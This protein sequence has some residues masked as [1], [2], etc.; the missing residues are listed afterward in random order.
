MTPATHR[1]E[2]SKRLKERSTCQSNRWCFLPKGKLLDLRGAVDVDASANQQDADNVLKT[3]HLEALDEQFEFET[4]ADGKVKLSIP[5]ESAADL[6]TWTLTVAA[7]T[8]QGNVGGIRLRDIT[9]NAFLEDGLLMFDPSKAR[10][11]DRP[12]ADVTV[13]VAWPLPN[14]AVESISKTGTVEVIGNNVPT[15]IGLGFFDRQMANAKIEY[16]AQPQ[17]AA[18]L[19]SEI[20]GGISFQTTIR[21]PSGG[22]RPVEQWDVDASMYNSTLTLGDESIDRIQSTINIQNGL[23]SVNALRGVVNNGGQLQGNG[24]FDLRSRSIESLTLKTSKIPASWLANAIIEGD[25]SGSFAKRTGLN[26]DN[27]AEKLT[28]TFAAEISIDPKDSKNFLWSA[29]SKKLTFFGGSFTDFTAAGHY[30]GHLDIENVVT[31]LPGGGAA[32]LEGDWIADVGEGRFQLQWNEASLATLLKSQVILPESF[33]ATSDGDLEI[34]LVEGQPVF[35]GVFDVVQPHIFGATFA[36]HRFDIST[37]DSRILFRDVPNKEQKTVS[38]DGSIAMSRPYDFALK[39]SSNSMPVSTAIF[40]KLSG[41]A[42][43]AFQATGQASP[44]KVES[45]G[46]FDLNNLSFNNTQLSDIRSRWNFDSDKVEEQKLEFAGLGG[47]AILDTKES[48]LDALRFRTKDIELSQLGVFQELPVEL[49]GSVTGIATI[50]NWRDPEARTINLSGESKSM[51]VGAAK[52]TNVEANAAISDGGRNI[53]YAFESQFL[54]GKLTGSGNKTLESLS[55]AASASYP[56]KMKI[57]N[58]R[59]KE[60]VESVSSQSNNIAKELSGRVSANVDWELTPGKSPAASGQVSVEDIK[61]RSRLASRSVSSPI[62]LSK[63]ILEVK[64]IRAELKQGKISGKATIP[65]GSNV[66][67]SYELGVRS[68]SLP[69]LLYVLVDEPLEAAGVIDARLQGRI[70]RTITGSGT[71]GLSEAGLFGTSSESMKI[72]IRY[73]A[74][75]AQ[76]KMLFEVPNSRIKA[77]QGTVEGHAKLEIGSRIRIDSK[78]E[79]SN[80]DSQ[81]FLHTLSGYEKPGTGQL[82]GK[83]DVSARNYS[84]PKDIAATFTGRLKQTNAFSIPLFSQLAGFLGNGPSLRSGKFDSDK[85]E[86]VLSKGRVEVRQFRLQSSLVSILVT[87]DAWINGKLDM[88]VAAR[89]ERLNQPTLIDQLAGSPIARAAGP[90]AA[91]IAQAADFLSE[92]IVFIDVSGTFNRPQLRLKPGKQLKEEAIRYFLRGS[93]IFP[94]A[95]GQNN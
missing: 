32:R 45:T 93:Q 87:G 92:R 62:S 15:K 46:E 58:A 80:V 52:L 3:F 55:D 94:N 12:D 57:V 2:K 29:D 73:L 77:F 21:L 53:E 59:L 72:P 33:D 11:T 50:K 26:S 63:G 18:L 70:G 95:I 90:Q 68:L 38:F 60:L 47:K 44:W 78:L 25:S 71:L 28:G 19:K 16:A 79:L 54:E 66:T 83:L 23:L 8:D 10:L 27:V 30:D 43:T 35:K 76:S 5:L 9:V 51:S 85:I 24:G 4:V 48:G 89:I 37:R 22:E 65:L 67:G 49:S 64:A 39:G 61:Y 20:D 81:K 34:T 42:T 86:L 41:S 36:D 40:D 91:F 14:A 7:E 74:N 56:L 31:L 17:V 82:S 1:T 13:K 75:P 6:R 69:R 88:E 84:S